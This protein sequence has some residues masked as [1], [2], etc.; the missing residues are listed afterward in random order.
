M[1]AKGIVIHHSASGDVS[2]NEIDRWHRQK[3]WDQVGYHFVIRKNGSIEPGRSFEV[4][5]AHKRGK[6]STH[7]G[8]C[9]TGDFTKHKPSKQQLSALMHLVEGLINRFDIQ[10]VIGHHD[11]CPGPNFSLDLDFFN[12]Y[13]EGG[14]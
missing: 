1:D 8:V 14:C 7:L 13:I 5:G 9:L 12:Q 4:A 10:E 3:G 2:A 6:N 11:N